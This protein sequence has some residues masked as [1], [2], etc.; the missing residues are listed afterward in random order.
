MIHPQ[1]WKKIK[2]SLKFFARRADIEEGLE[3]AA[4]LVKPYRRKFTIPLQKSV[5]VAL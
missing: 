1:K 2:K 5:D 4:R 3:F